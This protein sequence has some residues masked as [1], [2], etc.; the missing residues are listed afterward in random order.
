[1]RW[2]LQGDINRPLSL[3]AGGARACFLVWSWSCHCL[4][5]FFFLVFIYF[6]FGCT[7]TLL[8]HRGFLKLQQ[9]GAAL[10]L[11]RTG[12]SLR[13]LLL[14]WCR[15]SRA[16][17]RRCCGSWALEHGL[18]RYGTRTPLPHSTWDL[19]R[20]GMEPVSPPPALAG[21]FLTTGP[22]GKSL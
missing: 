6:N 2:I 19:P 16:H 11:Q 20:P 4:F 1:M 5:F 3:E 14:L 9:V 7:G 21:G 12:F 13:W 22:P 18:S 15:G 10:K 17:S 8:L